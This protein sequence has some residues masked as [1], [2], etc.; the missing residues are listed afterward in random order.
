[1]INPYQPVIDQLFKERWSQ[2]Q[3]STFDQLTDILPIIYAVGCHD[4]GDFIK[5]F[6]ERTGTASD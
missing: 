2:R 4:A 1:M 5:R 3:D 6:I